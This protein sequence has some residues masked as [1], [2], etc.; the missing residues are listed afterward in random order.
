[1]LFCY[2][3]VYLIYCSLKTERCH[4]I[5]PWTIKSYRISLE[6][7]RI[8]HQW[9]GFKPQFTQ[10]QERGPRFHHSLKFPLNFCHIWQ[11]RTKIRTQRISLK[12][13]IFV[14]LRN[15]KIFVTLDSG[16]FVDVCTVPKFQT[17]YF[18]TSVFLD[19]K[20]SI[21]LSNDVQLFIFIRRTGWKRLDSVPAP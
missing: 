11:T 6:N 2:F 9:K 16:N 10:L 4:K 19:Q 7:R 8:Q 20:C 3:S 12:C 15:F 14:T 21:V 18:I 17:A 5:V 1:M 13:N